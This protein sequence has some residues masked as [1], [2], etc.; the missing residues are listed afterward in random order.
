MGTAFF[1]PRTGA[2]APWR[3]VRPPA[4]GIETAGRGPRAA[5]LAVSL[6][7]ALSFLGLRPEPGG[8]IRVGGEAPGAAAAWLR[9]E[10]DVEGVSAPALDARGF[11]PEDFRYLCLKTHYRRRMDFSWEALGAARAE[12]ARLLDAAR[13][14]SGVTQEPSARALSGYLQRVREA[15]SRD[16]D[17]PEALACVWDA[18]RPGA[19][20]PGSRAALLRASGA[21]LTIPNSRP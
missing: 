13:G 21:L 10:G 20:S 7:E 11:S 17:L 15:L 8:E 19:L 18:L 2:L 1:D 14:L 12:R 16:L 3:P 4:A 5:A 6:A 9:L